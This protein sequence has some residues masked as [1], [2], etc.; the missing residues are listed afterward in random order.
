M[1]AQG[2]ALGIGQIQQLSPNVGG[3]IVPGK[4]QG[5]PDWGSVG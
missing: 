5:R 1:P 4:S 2:N 3:S